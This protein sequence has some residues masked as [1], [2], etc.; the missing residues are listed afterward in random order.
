M[1]HEFGDSNKFTFV[2]GSANAA[3]RYFPELTVLQMVD[4]G[5][6]MRDRT[7]VSRLKR[8]AHRLRLKLWRYSSDLGLGDVLLSPEERA[9]KAVY[10]SADI[11]IST[12]GTYL[13]EHYD[14]HPRLLE[15]ELALSS[16]RPLMMFT[17]SLGP[18]RK[19]DNIARI[20]RLAERAVCVLLRD[21]LSRRHLLEVGVKH[22]NTSI[23]G[24]AA[25][26]LR[27][28]SARTATS[29][30]RR[31]AISVRSWTHF[32]RRDGMPAYK[33]AIAR[34]VEHLIRNRACSVTFVSTCQGTPEYWT[35]DSATAF[36]ILSLL[37]DA[38]KSQVTVNS[39]FNRPDALLT[40]LQDFDLVI[41]TR[42]HVAI[43]ALCAGVPVF[44]IAYE[45]KTRELF[46]VSL[47]AP[48]WVLGIEDLT[49]NMLIERVEALFGAMPDLSA[50]LAN[51][52]TRL[53][54]SA[55]ATGKL[56]RDELERSRC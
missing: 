43:L 55:L 30:V 13:V 44:P 47:G 36:E 29:A 45:F 56:V 53:R 16:G 4:P 32:S 42:M 8:A 38:S 3:R 22:A 25:F 6:G 18:F 26:A 24:D 35:D 10:A 17:Q 9:G 49:A 54:A 31:V 33:Q 51:G 52:V 46:D 11:I 14:L 23:A 19:A 50:Q 37:D 27:P 34:T 28:R 39:Q 1:R 12:G 20:R 40:Y 5:A 48:G 7:P 41:A 21:E 2:D 15:L